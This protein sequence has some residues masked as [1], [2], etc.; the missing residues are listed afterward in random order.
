MQSVHLSGFYAWFKEPLSQ[1]AIDDQRQTRL[2]K[3]AKKDSGKDYGYSK[4]YDDLSDMG[5]AVS[6]NRVARLDR[7]AGIQAQIG[8]KKKP[9]VYGGKPSVVVD[10]TLARQF[11]VDAPGRVWV[12]D[13]AY[14]CVVLDLFARR[15]VGWAVQSYQTSE[16]VVQALLMAIWRRKPGLGL[17]TSI[18]IKE[19]SS[20]AM[21]GP[22]SCANTIW[23]I[24]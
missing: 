17:L 1:R 22:P 14:L 24:R 7:V 13:F 11:G 8:N 16:L 3:K 12:T 19:P 4:I 2:L 23:N 20:P 6:E 15:V 9:E 18:L 10:N 5:E 21:N